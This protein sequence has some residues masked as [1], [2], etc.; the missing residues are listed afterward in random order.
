[1]K[2][3]DGRIYAGDFRTN[4]KHGH[5]KFTWGT[6]ASFEGKFKNNVMEGE[7]VY[8]WESGAKRKGNWED[9]N[10]K[11]WIGEAFSD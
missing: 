9:G 6:G 1:M 3:P 8:K 5:G 2:Y 4:M 10:F 11:E 7:G